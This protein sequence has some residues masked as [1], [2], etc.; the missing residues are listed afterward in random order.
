MVCG[1]T[2]WQ[3]SLNKRDIIS[4]EKCVAQRF[5]FMSRTWRVLFS[6]TSSNFCRVMWLCSL[7]FLRRKFSLNFLVDILSL[8]SNTVNMETTE[9]FCWSTNWK[10]QA[11]LSCR[12]TH[13]MCWG[14][15]LK[16]ALSLTSC[17][18]FYVS[19]DTTVQAALCTFYLPDKLLLFNLV[20]I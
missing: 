13:Q 1:L 20:Q 3:V 12:A 15:K 6:R 5:Y 2:H 18:Q 8:V 4:I 11:T 19:D 10:L 14:T 17:S 16:L 9:T 7:T